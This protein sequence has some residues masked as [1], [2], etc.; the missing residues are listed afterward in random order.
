[1]FKIM[2]LLLH[3]SSLFNFFYEYLIILSITNSSSMKHLVR[4]STNIIE[5]TKR[6]CVAGL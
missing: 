3:L 5:I 1:M 6:S 4:K 2:K